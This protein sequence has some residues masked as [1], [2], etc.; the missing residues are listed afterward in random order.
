MSSPRRWTACYGFEGVYE[1]S[2]HGELRRLPGGAV[3]STN[4]AIK[5]LRTCTLYRDGIAHTK[6]VQSLVLCSF[7]E[8]RPPR[9]R[10]THLNGNKLDCRLEN[11]QWREPQ[12][13]IRRAKA[14]RRRKAKF[15]DEAKRREAVEQ[16]AIALLDKLDP[17]HIVLNPQVTAFVDA[18]TRAE[19]AIGSQSRG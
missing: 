19:Q 17:R 3:L 1:I 6:V 8:V 12:T 16:I 10:I 18:Y 9:T 2:D 11:L 13:R 5:G 15:G 4:N 14:S 7:G